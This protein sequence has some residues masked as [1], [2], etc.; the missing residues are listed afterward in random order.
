MLDFTVYKLSVM[1]S[2]LAGDAVQLSASLGRFVELCA[3]VDVGIDNARSEEEIRSLVVWPVPTLDWPSAASLLLI[4]ISIT[5][6]HIDRIGGHQSTSRSNGS[7]AWY[8][9][10]QQL[11]ASR[12]AHTLK[13]RKEMSLAEQAHIAIARNNILM[14]RCVL[15][16]SERYLWHR[17]L[18]CRI[19]EQKRSLVWDTM[20]KAY[21]HLAIDRVLLSDK[22]PDDESAVENE[23]LREDWLEKMLLVDVELLPPSPSE[24]ARTSPSIA[25]PHVKATLEGLNAVR[26]HRLEAL[27]DAFKLPQ[28][29]GQAHGLSRWHDRLGR[30]AGKTV[31][32]VR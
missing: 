8:Q 22:N 2:L 7:L 15:L 10:K 28:T 23:T 26:A 24:M 12:L 11:C 27:F 31:I 18:L 29:S 5:A 13:A 6:G 32:K 30:Q 20:R 9:Q 3:T 4:W 21:V 1:L 16:N 14:L 17:I 25:S 19:V